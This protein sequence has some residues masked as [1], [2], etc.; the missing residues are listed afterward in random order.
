MHESYLVKQTD[1]YLLNLFDSEIMTYKI[2][3]KIIKT[4]YK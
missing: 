3:L 4:L 1:S 2:N